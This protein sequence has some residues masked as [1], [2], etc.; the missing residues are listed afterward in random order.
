VNSSNR[1]SPELQQRI[2]ARFCAAVTGVVLAGLAA[3]TISAE[4]AL[5]RTSTIAAPYPMTIY[6]Q[7]PTPGTR[8]PGSRGVAGADFS[9]V[10]TSALALRHGE[11]A[12]QT[13]PGPYADRFGRPPGYPPLMNWIAVPISLL[14][15]TTALLVYTALGFAC[16]VA[17]TGFLLWKAGLQRHI[18]QVVLAQFCLYFL[19]PIGLTCLER[20]QFDSLVATAGALCAGC[21]FLTGSTWAVALL[22]GFL[23]ALKWTS[24]AFLGCYALL[25]FLLSSGR[26]RWS[27][28]LIPVVMVVGTLSF[29]PE[30][31]KYWR[32][33]QVY[34]IDAQPYGLTLQYYLP[35]TLARMVPVA[36]T[37]VAVALGWIC[38]RSAVERTLVLRQIS[39]PFAIALMNVAVC[40]GTLSYEYHT[41]AT[42]GMMPGLVIWTRRADG[43]PNWLKASTCAAFGLF[44]IVAF[45]TYGFGALSPQQMTAIYIGFALLFFSVSVYTLVRPSI[46]ARR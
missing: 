36:M 15:Y 23:G 45:R 40:F 27:F 11:S 7:M 35:R 8:V 16:L 28:F 9:Q 39:A 3:A 5:L 34:E 21:I 24:A 30:L 32:T 31:V 25:G 29:W 44:L 12:Y 22:S 17:A 18:V 10:Y 26:R 37:L 13:K 43:L 19:T 20:G 14:D 33:I 1:N 41:V 6:E 46:Q 42:L 2:I 38:S 4:S